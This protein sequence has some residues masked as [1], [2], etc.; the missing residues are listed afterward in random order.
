MVSFQQS[1]D[2]GLTSGQFQ[3]SLS[4]VV[5][6]NVYKPTNPVQCSLSDLKRLGT[7]RAVYRS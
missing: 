3:R 4:S 2:F 1:F 5:P 7:P 6:K